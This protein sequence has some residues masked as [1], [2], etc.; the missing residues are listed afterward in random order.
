MYIMFYIMGV[1]Y[2]CVLL[3]QLKLFIEM[4]LALVYLIVIEEH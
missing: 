4:S 1:Y 2:G 3:T